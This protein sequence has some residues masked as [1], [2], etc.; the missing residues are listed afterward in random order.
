MTPEERAW[1]TLEE[2]KKQY[3]VEG[4]SHEEMFV[5]GFVI[6]YQVGS[7]EMK[8]KIKQSICIPYERV[9]RGW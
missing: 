7:H 9:E 8:E 5:S 6:G 1:R 2:N 4:R 3:S